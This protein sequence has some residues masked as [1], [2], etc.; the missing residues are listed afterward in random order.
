MCIILGVMLVIIKKCES[1][2]IKKHSTT[3]WQSKGGNNGNLGM[4]S[5]PKPPFC[6]VLFSYHL[7]FSLYGKTIR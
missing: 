3:L 5:T 7:L 4:A 6:G 1:R 2:K